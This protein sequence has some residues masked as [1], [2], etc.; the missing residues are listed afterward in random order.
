MST[1]SRFGEVL[2]LFG[3]AKSAWSVREISEALG[4]PV[5]TT[6]RMVKEMLDEGF[7]EATR[8]HPTGFTHEFGV[9]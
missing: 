6:Y 4:I 2:R 7:L 1:L 9:R 5:N 3:E 8:G